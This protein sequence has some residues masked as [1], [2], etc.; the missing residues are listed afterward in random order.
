MNI[1]VEIQ[2]CRLVVLEGIHLLSERQVVKVQTL[3]GQRCRAL[4]EQQITRAGG[5]VFDVLRTTGDR[6]LGCEARVLLRC[7]GILLCLSWQSDMAGIKNNGALPWRRKDDT[8]YSCR[9]R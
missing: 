2:V 9:G 8:R 7:A 3:M 5:V 4:R 1:P 6:W